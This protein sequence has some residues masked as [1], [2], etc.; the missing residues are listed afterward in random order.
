MCSSGPFNQHSQTQALKDPTLPQRTQMSIPQIVT[1]LEFCLKNMYFLFHGK[2]YEQVQGTAMG[3]PISLLIAN[4]FIEESE[5]K[6]LTTASI[7]CCLWLRFV[8]D[9][10]VIHKAEHSTQ[11]L[12]HINSQ[13]PNIQFTVEQPGLDGSIPFLDTKVTPGPNNT[14][15]T[16]VYRKPTHTDQCLH[17]DSNHFTTAKNSVYNTLAHTAK[18]VSSAPAELAKELDHLRKALQACLFPNWTLNRLQHQFEFKHNNN[19]KANQTEG[20]Q[21]NHHNNRDNTNNKQYKNISMVVPYIHGLGQKFKR[22]CN[23]QGIQVHFKGTNTIKQLLMT[24]KDR[25]SK[26]QKSGVIYKYK[27][28]QI[29]YTEGY[30]G[31]SGRTFGDIYKEHLKAPSPIHLHTTTTGHPISPDCFSIVDREAQGM[32]KEAMYISINDS[33]LNRNLG[34]FQLPHVWDQVLQDPPSLHLK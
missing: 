7:P 19:S 21:S 29:N 17:W 6:A 16:T 26:L 34:K 31:E 5:V 3:F 13:D 32:A 15:H 4:P 8:N 22:T 33:S 14:I 20:Q 25:D 23:K 12:H 30:V 10:L 18:V 28:P 2:Y 11:L 9:T 1:L 27:C 24:P